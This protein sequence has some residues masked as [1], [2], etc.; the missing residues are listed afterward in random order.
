MSRDEW[1]VLV[2]CLLTTIFLL[3]LSISFS[4]KLSQGYTL[5]GDSGNYNGA[6]ETEGPTSS[7]IL[8]L[9]FYWLTTALLLALDVF[10]AFFKKLKGNEVIQK[11][12]VDGKTIEIREEE[13][14]SK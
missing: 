9:S 3:Y 4:V 7:D 14:D 8:V 11:D 10:L 1:I 5:F 13:N 2:T 12:I 6:L